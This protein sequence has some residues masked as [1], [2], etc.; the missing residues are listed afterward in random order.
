MSNG[1]K[2]LAVIPARGGSKGLPGKNLADL[3]GISML[4]HSILATRSCPLISRC[5]V[6]TDSFRIAAEAERYKVEVPFLRPSNLATDTANLGDVMKHLL[7]ELDEREGYKPDSLVVLFPTHPFRTSKM[8]KDLVGKLANGYHR[9]LTVK[10]I[11]VGTMNFFVPNRQGLVSLHGN[12]TTYSCCRPYGLFVGYWVKQQAKSFKTYTHVLTSQ[13]EL[14][15][16][17]TYRDLERAN[18]IIDN[19]DFIPEWL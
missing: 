14:V 19:G 12:R 4:A 17:D 16:I 11:D 2:V 13:A 10:Q 3:G 18:Q 15:D 8:M 5:I 7:M 1:K 6:S 9:V